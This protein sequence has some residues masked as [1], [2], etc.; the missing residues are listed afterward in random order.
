MAFFFC[1]KCGLAT[2]W[3]CPNCQTWLCS[4]D[5]EGHRCTPEKNEAMYPAKEAEY[6]TK[7]VTPRKR[8]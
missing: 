5:R 7:V 8:K 6:E 2:S 4:T 1:K 3:Q